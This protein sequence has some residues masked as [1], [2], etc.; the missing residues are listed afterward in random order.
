MTRANLFVGVVGVLVGALLV[1]G[2]ITFAFGSEWWNER[3]KARQLADRAQCE[4]LDVAGAR[5]GAQCWMQFWKEWHN[6]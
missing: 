1:A 5:S 2:S 3:L 4:A 6:R